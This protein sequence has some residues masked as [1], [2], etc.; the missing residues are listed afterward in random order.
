M[1]ECV[2]DWTLIL[3]D[4]SCVTVAYVDFSKA[5]DTLSHAKRFAR[6]RPYGIQGPLLKWMQN[7]LTGRIQ[8]TRIGCSL[9]EVADL[10]SGVVQGSEPIG[11]VL[12][13][14]FIDGLAKVLES[15]GV[16]TK[17]LPMM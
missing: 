7:F 6:L 10:L 17:F 5:F 4:K 3:Q 12:F 1:L 14:V 2:N 16:V 11:P 15:I 8:Q 9:S 13:L